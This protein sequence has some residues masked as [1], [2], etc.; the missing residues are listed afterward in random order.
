MKAETFRVKFTQHQRKSGALWKEL[1]FELRN[2]FEG[3]DLVEHEF[4]LISN[5][6]IL[7]KPYRTSQRQNEILKCEIKRM[8]DFNIIEIGQSDYASPMMLVEAPGKDPRLCIHYRLLNANV[9]TQFFPLPNI[10][11]SVERVTDA[12]Y[13]MVTDLAKG[14]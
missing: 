6:P 4:E 12:K 7:A 8:L 10:E 14:Y 3:W 2:Y 9:R 11:E 1:F 5:K 13:I